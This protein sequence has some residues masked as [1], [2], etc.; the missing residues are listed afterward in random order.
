VE[1]VEVIQEVVVEEQEVIELHIVH[2][3]FQKYY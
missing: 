3:E 1:E 2:Q